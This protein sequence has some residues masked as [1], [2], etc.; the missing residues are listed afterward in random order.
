[1]MMHAPIGIFISTPGGRYVYVNL[2]LT[3]M[4]GYDSPQEAMDSIENIGEQ[5][6][7]DPEE[8]GKI[9][10]WLEE[11]DERLNLECRF[12]RKDGSRFWG[13]YNVR[14]VRNDKGEI[15]YYE[16]FA[17]DISDRKQT[18][19]SLLRTQFAMDRAPDSILWIDDEG[20][21]VYANDS[22]CASMGYEREELL[23]MKVFDIDPD[24][25]PDQWE[26]HKKTVRKLGSLTFESRHRAK[27]GSTF[28]VE[29]S[30]NHF[31]F[32]DHYLA[33]AFDR[34]ITGRKRAEMAL[35]ESEEKY[36]GLVEG[37]HEALFRMSLP[38]GKYEYISP[39]AIHVLGYSA[40]TCYA[41]PLLVEKAAHPDYRE[42]VKEALEK[43]IR[44]EVPPTLEYKIIDSEGK[45]RWIFQS[46]KGIF[47]DG[48]NIIAVEG[49]CR[50]ITE[51]KRAEE[52]LR[53][54]E[55]RFRRFAEIAP[56]GIV[57]LDRNGDPSYVSHKFLDLFGYQREDLSSMEAWWPL[58]YP[59]E[60]LRNRV[61]REWQ[62]AVESA[63][64]TRSEI[65]PLEYPV[66]CRDGSVRLIEFRM[67]AAGDLDIVLFM[68]VTDRR[69]KEE[70]RKNLE[71]RLRQ[72]RRLESVGTLAGGIAHEF[73]NLLMGIQG[74]ASLMMLDLEPS[75]PH[76]ERLKRI[77]RQVQS[78]ARLT[79]QLLG[80][81]RGGRYRSN[82]ISMNVIIDKIASI[83]ERTRKELTIHRRFS[84]DLW[85]VEADTSQMDQVFMNLFMNADEAM[86][87]G[88]DI[89]LETEN[90]LLD[91]MQA[92]P[93]D[94]SAGKYV[95]IAVSDTGKG[96]DAET[97]ERIYEPFFTT[98]GT[99]KS[100]GLGLPA[101]YGIIR[102][103]GGAIDVA[104]EPGLG[105]TFRI[106]LPVAE[107]TV[108]EE[109]G[110]RTEAVK[111]KETILIVDDEA[112]ILEVTQGMLRSMGYQVFCAGSGREALDI[113]REKGGRI[114][115]IVLDMIMPGMSGTETF[116]RLR[117]LDPNGKILLCSGYSIEG[118]AA[119]LIEKGCGGFIQKPFRMED[120]SR[121]VRTILDR[122]E[123]S[124]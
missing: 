11:H 16:G 79:S 53:E 59:D 73:N 34:D 117:E 36:R 109:K 54:S 100:A 50:D 39:A 9:L 83:F 94:L 70:E 45:E 2:V 115:L 69:R 105:T 89:F 91:E 30:T 86:P 111:G 6:Y 21:I 123:E 40:E 124:S 97:L 93:L 51:G 114:D 75:H 116:E 46:N 25:P 8:R 119:K 103:H 58:A 90:V 14:A 42:F 88:G 3:R 107:K 5:I 81:A 49:I 12:V 26:Q 71:D 120:L 121:E 68:D 80:F 43:M 22:A 1:M 96:M 48:G 57:I 66:T 15:I 87:G 92:A 10:R 74:N 33:C 118:K 76:Y 20:R 60:T 102:G 63:R 7:S 65:T 78:G 24:F 61:Q 27:N 84:G 72:A 104:S 55:S 98:K 64:K 67:A 62:E 52:A 41:N 4:L 44:G 35:R 32:D 38:D 17:W 110:A 77:E 29:V 23:K 18:E 99:G 95:R 28:P 101:A 122:K 47:D 13:A 37:L 31:K 85:V 19:Q 56:A 113:Y 108:I 82:P 106:Y 112:I